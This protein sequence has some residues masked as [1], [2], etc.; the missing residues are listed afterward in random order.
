MRTHIKTT[1]FDLTESLKVLV[2]EKLTVVA[3]KL[4]ESLD[5][6]A[7]IILDVELA[8]TS[9]HHHEGKIWKCEAGLSVPHISHVLRAEALSESMEG[10]VDAAKDILEREIK[11]YKETR[12]I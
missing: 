3:G 4:L 11:K 5:A 1:N 7:D 10:A 9:K 12:N 8:K 2:N 6:S